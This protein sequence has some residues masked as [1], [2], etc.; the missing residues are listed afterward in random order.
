MS[1]YLINTNAL[2]GEDIAE[3]IK[4]GLATKMNITMEQ[5]YWRMYECYLEV[6][7]FE[8]I[9]IVYDKKE[10]EYIAH[11]RIN[12]GFGATE[13]EALQDYIKDRDDPDWKK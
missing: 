5:L 10:N 3:L 2:H 9:R 7:P 11:N 12:H 6:V 13:L 1:Q 4:L 8:G